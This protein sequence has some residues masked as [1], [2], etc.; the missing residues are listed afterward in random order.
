M[1]WLLNQT[2]AQGGYSPTDPNIIAGVDE[3]GYKLYVPQA[4]FNN[5]VGTS[6]NVGVTIENLGVAPFY[7]PWTVVLALLDGS[8]N[9][10]QT[11]NTSWDLRT[12]QPLTIRAFPDWNV[13]ADPTYI[14]YGC[15]DE[16][17]DQYQARAA[18]PPAT[19][20]WRCG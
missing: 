12:V 9:V 16:F 3:M 14:S 8:G 4:N 18:S 13:G 15:A 7:Y 6:F 5:S 17:P 10:V 1:T 19:T 2:G 20:L 11:W